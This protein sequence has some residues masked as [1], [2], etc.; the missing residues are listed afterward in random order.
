MTNSSDNP[1]GGSKQL[2]IPQHPLLDA[3]LLPSSSHSF[4][5]PGLPPVPTLSGQAVSSAATDANISRV[6]GLYNE[7]LSAVDNKDVPALK[8]AVEKISRFGVLHPREAQPLIDCGYYKD[9]YRKVNAHLASDSVLN[10]SKRPHE[11][12]FNAHTPTENKPFKVA[13]EA[14]NDVRTVCGGTTVTSSL[15]QLTPTSPP[16]SC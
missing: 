12:A 4:S 9:A 2:I 15:S 1:V 13:K 11:V 8:V 3:S 6:E 10:T 14:P 16:R 5:L 7:L